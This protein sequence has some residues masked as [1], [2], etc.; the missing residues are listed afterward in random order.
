SPILMGRRT[1]EDHEGVLPGRTNVVLTR[2]PDFHAAEGVLIRR[3]LDAAVLEIE[4]H[5]FG[6]DAT[7]DSPDLVAI[8]RDWVRRGR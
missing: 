2:R 3:D 6:S 4:A 1:Y 5:Y 8:A 7:G